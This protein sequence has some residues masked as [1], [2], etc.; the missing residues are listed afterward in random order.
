VGGCLA[1]TR[2][3]QGT[4]GAMISVRPMGCRSSLMFSLSAGRPDAGPAGRTPVS[5]N[6]CG[7]GIG[8]EGRFELM[9]GDRKLFVT[10][11][12]ELAKGE[13]FPLLVTLADGKFQCLPERCLARNAARSAGAIRMGIGHADV[14]KL[15]ALAQGVHGGDAHRQPLRRCPDGQ[16]VVRPIIEHP[17]PARGRHVRGHSGDKRLGNPCERLGRLDRC[18][19][20]TFKGI[21]RLRSAVKVWT[22]SGLVSGVE[23]YWFEFSVR[24]AG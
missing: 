3:R 16:Q 20:Y 19:R 17:E 23:G 21:V 5:P 8:G 7:T 14:R 9:R 12:R 2:F 10:P 18:G 22:F 4:P 24:C 15:A 13:H 6:T 1:V 11:M